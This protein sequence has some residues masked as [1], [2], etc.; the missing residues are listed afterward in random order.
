VEICSCNLH[1]NLHKASNNFPFGICERDWGLRR[2]VLTRMGGG[3]GGF[4]Q[5]LLEFLS[6]KLM[7]EGFR[8]CSGREDNRARREV[9][10][11]SR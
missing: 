11:S 3:C 10:L 7:I 4:E 5:L 1:V 9:N 8:D 2:G 6:K